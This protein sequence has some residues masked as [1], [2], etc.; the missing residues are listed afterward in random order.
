M[1]DSGG[2]VVVFCTQYKGHQKRMMPIVAGLIG[3]GIPV[4]VFADQGA[5]A[6]MEGVGAGFSDLYWRQ[7]YT[8]IDPGTTRPTSGWSVTFAGLY[9]EDVA[10]EVEP[11]RPRLIL[12]DT[13]MPVARVVAIRLGLPRVVMRMG[14]AFDPQKLRQR[15]A[16][17]PSM[18]PS[19]SDKCREAVRI[20]QEKHGIAEASPFLAFSDAGGEL[21]IY[22]E[23]S[24]FMAARPGEPPD[25]VEYFGSL[26]PASHSAADGAPSPFGPLSEGR[27]R[28]YISFGTVVWDVH[29]SEAQAALEALA[30]AIAEMP[31]VAALIS[32]GGGDLPALAARLARRNVRVERYVDQIRVLRDAS[33]F[34]THHGMNSTHEAIYYGV[35]MISYPFIWDQPGIAARCQ[36]LGL[37]VPLAP[38]PLARVSVPDVRRALDR[39][40]S[41]GDELRRRLAEARQW[42]LDVIARRPAV[43]E[44]IKALMA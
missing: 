1:T 6:D 25:T 22:S 8:E 44:R 15:Y 43:I 2:G 41:G 33:V 13:L 20:L 10:R 3:A 24:Q 42:E 30:D 39:I 21:N 12:H 4:H 11:L 27:V 29:A 17:D 18:A 32:L 5:R 38:E 36:E 37:A 34:V 35:P 26:W 40:A 19:V 7:P 28:V 14:Q 31:A 16:T 9:G 23:P